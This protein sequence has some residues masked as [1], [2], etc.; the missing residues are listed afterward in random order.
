MVGMHSIEEEIIPNNLE[1]H[2]FI[3]M[4]HEKDIFMLRDRTHDLK[5]NMEGLSLNVKL[6]QNNLS[7]IK[8]FQNEIS[9]KLESI[10]RSVENLEYIKKML[11]TSKFWLLVV[12][13]SFIGVI[14]I[15]DNFSVFK[16]IFGL[17]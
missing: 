15:I 3:L 17:F 4:R 7:E 8:S 12:W 13:I 14:V 5:S 11:T 2:S 1:A 9:S 10:S 16:K 6:I